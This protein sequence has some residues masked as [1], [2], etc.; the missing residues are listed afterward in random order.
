MCIDNRKF[1]TYCP[2][3]F[4]TPTP[5]QIEEAARSAGLSIIALCREVGIA[6]STFVRWK[7]GAGISIET[8]RSMEQAIEARRAA[9]ERA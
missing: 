3:M 7:G 2:T 9:R 5:Q 1:A 8:V 6:P 4:Q